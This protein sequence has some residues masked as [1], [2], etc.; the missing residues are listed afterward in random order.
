MCDFSINEYRFLIYVLYDEKEEQADVD[1]ISE[2]G[3]SIYVHV[4]HL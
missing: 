2:N 3:C 4:Y 1:R